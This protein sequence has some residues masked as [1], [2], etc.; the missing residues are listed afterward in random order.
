MVPKTFSRSIASFSQLLDNST[1]IAFKCFASAATADSTQ[2][3]ALSRRPLG[4]PCI[5]C[6]PIDSNQP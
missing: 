6:V 3:A 1:S 5:G 2:R 4:L